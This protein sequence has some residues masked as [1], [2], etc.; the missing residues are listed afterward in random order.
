MQPGSYKIVK[1]GEPF[2]TRIDFATVTASLRYRLR[3]RG[4]RRNHGLS[5]L[6]RGHRRAAEGFE[7]VGIRTALNVGGTLWLNQKK[8]VVGKT[9]G[10]TSL[11]GLFGNFSLVFDQGSHFLSVNSDLQLNIR[12]PEVGEPASTTDY[13]EGSALY[14]F[15]INNPYFGPYA[16]ASF[17]TSVFPGYLY[18]EDLGNTGQVRVN[19]PDGSTETY[20]FGSEAHPDDLRIQLSEPLSPFII[21]EEIGGTSKR[22]TWTWHCSSCR[23]RPEPAGDFAM[24]SPTAC[25]SWT[26]KNAALPII[27]NEV[28]NYFHHG[29]GARC[30]R[31]CDLCPLAVW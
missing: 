15:N 29:P 17:K 23:W 14:A 8:D 10:V 6:R 28:E 21:Q 7:V 27:L 16:R 9:N 24:A 13:F 25:W 12:D 1:A 18:L 2:E 22:S 4:R 31:H 19:R 26:V 11:V 3:H 30:Q 20:V 5:R